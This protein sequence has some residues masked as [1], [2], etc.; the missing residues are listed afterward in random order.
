VLDPRE[1][2]SLLS[3]VFCSAWAS[4]S[5]S[6]GGELPRQGSSTWVAWSVFGRTPPLDLQM[7]IPALKVAAVTRHPPRPVSFKVALKVA[8]VIR[9]SAEMTR[10][11]L[12]LL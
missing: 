3:S 2:R 1:H 12:D 6:A 7:L 11:Q 9:H 10:M 8:G 5:L 4:S